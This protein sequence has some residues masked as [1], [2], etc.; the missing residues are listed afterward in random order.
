[1]SSFYLNYFLKQRYKTF[2]NGSINESLAVDELPINIYL[3][4][5]SSYEYF[6]EHFFQWKTVC[7]RK[8][9]FENDRNALS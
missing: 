2:T 9:L 5:Y 7:S 4:T 1:M 6:C 3:F 8:R